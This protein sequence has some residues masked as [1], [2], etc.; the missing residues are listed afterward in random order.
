VLFCCIIPFF[1]LVFKC[2]SIGEFEKKMRAFE[3]S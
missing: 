2:L 1:G 3:F